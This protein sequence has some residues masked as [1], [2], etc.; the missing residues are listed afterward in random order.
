MAPPP[1]APLDESDP[2]PRG[3]VRTAC[4]VVGCVGLAVVV[5]I[6][7]LVYIV[8]TVLADLTPPPST[9][10][11]DKEKEKEKKKVSAPFD[12]WPGEKPPLFARGPVV[13]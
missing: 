3:Q 10:P 4:A 12:P 7:A 11:K 9:A 8:L 6:A 5:A 2:L 13:S 1:A